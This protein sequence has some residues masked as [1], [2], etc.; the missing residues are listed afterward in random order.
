V[1]R[2]GKY[3]SLCLAVILAISTLIMVGYASGQTIPKP[4]VPEIPITITLV[5]AAVSLILITGTRKLT[6]NH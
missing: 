4:S 6:I 2:L 3:L 5:L 1:A